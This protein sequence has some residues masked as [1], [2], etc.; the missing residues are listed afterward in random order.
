MNAFPFALRSRLGSGLGA[1]S[2]LALAACGNGNN[3]PEGGMD[4]AAES[5]GPEASLTDVRPDVRP[6]GG[7]DAADVVTPDAPAPDVPRTPGG[8][9]DDTWGSR[10]WYV[11]TIPVAG[12]VVTSSALAVAGLSDGSVVWAGWTRTVMPAMGQE[13]PTIMHLVSNGRSTDMPYGS[14]LPLSDVTNGRFV[15]LSVAA[16]DSAMVLGN[17]APTTASMPGI[18]LAACLFALSPAG[19]ADTLFGST[20]GGAMRNGRLMLTPAGA[21][22][23]AGAVLAPASGGG[24]FVAMNRSAV[25]A[26]SYLGRRVR[27]GDADPTF[28]DTSLGEV[29]IVN[30]S[31]QLR[32]L[33]VQSDGKILGTG[34]T[35]G[36]SDS[37]IVLFRTQPTHGEAGSDLDPSFGSGGVV[38][39]NL[40]NDDV[41]SAVAVMPDGRI[42]VAGVAGAS[43]GSSAG[44][45]LVL[46]R[47]MPDG[48]LD[49]EWGTGGIVR[50]ALM[51]SFEL[52]AG[53]VLDSDG[54]VTVAGYASTA[55][56]SV[57]YR[58]TPTGAPDT[59][60]GNSGVLFLSNMGVTFVA[61]ALAP[62]G[63]TA[64][65]V[66]GEQL[67]ATTMRPSAAIVRVRR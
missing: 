53:V 15:S 36:S 52:A 30:E 25:M 60:F 7:M 61:R 49:L 66:S 11:Y 38:R 46:L 64:L 54:S 20:A 4:A 51:G 45:A 41:A 37:D 9:V 31:T 22:T 13:T 17:C 29:R 1:L 26:P 2:L 40:Q 67:D 6:D 8:V 65:W 63:T 3:M 34:R 48:T 18:S 21:S 62:A 14:M 12:V 43:G 58:F 16:N 27:N 33:A 57:A 42:V 35:A 59:S 5:S 47:Y 50:L 32:A 39:T 44:N 55:G 19:D 56:V 28:T 10:G 24:A 23:T